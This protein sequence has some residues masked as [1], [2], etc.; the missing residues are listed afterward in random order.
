MQFDNRS[1]AFDELFGH[2]PSEFESRLPTHQV[3]TDALSDPSVDPRTLGTE[4][5]TF[6][7]GMANVLHSQA[8]RD[9]AFGTQHMLRALTAVVDGSQQELSAGMVSSLR[10]GLTS[11]MTPPAYALS[12]AASE[13]PSVLTN[14][15]GNAASAAIAVGITALSSMGP[16]GAAAAAVIGFARSLVS[17]FTKRKEWEDQAIEEQRRRAYELMPPLQESGSETDTYYVQ[18]IVIPAMQRG[19]WTHLFAP[20]FNPRGEWVGAERDGGMAFAPGERNK[21]EQDQFGNDMTRFEP[22]GGVGFM[23]GQNRVTSVVQVSLNPIG[24]EVKYWYENGGPWPI[25]KSYVRDVG[26]FYVNTNRL[27]AV[28]WTWVANRSRSPHLYK[29]HVGTPESDDTTC[30]HYQWRSYCDGGLDFLHRNS[31]DWETPR[32]GRIGGRVKDPDKPEFL[33]GSAIGCAIGSWSCYTK[34]N[35]KYVQVFPFGYPHWQMKGSLGAPLGC[36]VDAPLG[37]IQAGGRLCLTTLYETHLKSTLKKVR[38]RQMWN[39]RHSLVCAYVRKSWDAFRDPV[40]AERLEEHRQ[41]L[42][43]HPSRFRVR[44]GDVPAGEILTDGRDFKSELLK[45]GV[46]KFG[47]PQQLTS[48]KPETLIDPGDDEE[49]EV[50]GFDARM[51]FDF[52]DEPAPE[53]E[54]RS[55]GRILGGVGLATAA[56]AA[57]AYAWKYRR[58]R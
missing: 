29:V 14:T 46:S 32:G 4:H 56:G 30:L 13:V 16:W 23:P 7:D 15:G 48:N 5:T 45:S 33:F 44:L 10:S 57:G 31:T 18:S 51:P 52:S 58:R 38:A 34:N 24:P 53:P 28:A 55:W 9:L 22:S 36:I 47:G 49:P 39:L 17:A 12:L 54:P 3:Y 8:V 27:A 25:K 6:G 26:D 35:G 50:D 1:P 20:R 42:L 19:S 40:L 2:L 41:L 21:N 43:K 37:L 11:A